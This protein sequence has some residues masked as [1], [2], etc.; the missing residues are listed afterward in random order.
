MRI[1]T[2]G[3]GI[4]DIRTT[5]QTQDGALILMETSGIVEFGTDGFARALAGHF[6]KTSPVILTPRFLTS[7]ARYTWLNRMQCLGVG[8]ADTEALAVHYDIYSVSFEVSSASGE[9]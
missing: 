1:R 9:D 5:I 8:Y 2:D 6:P 3:V 4:T 7:D